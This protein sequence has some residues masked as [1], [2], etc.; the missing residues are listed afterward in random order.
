M[1]FNVH[2][3][4]RW[5]GLRAGV[6]MVAKEAAREPSIISDGFGKVGDWEAPFIQSESWWVVVA[7][8]KWIVK[9]YCVGL[10]ILSHSDAI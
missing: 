5:E 9:Y 10:V 2:P 3:Y 4:A 7:V 1:D 6:S 8:G